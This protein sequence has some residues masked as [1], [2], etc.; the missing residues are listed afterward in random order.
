[1][2]SIHYLIH[3]QPNNDNNNSQTAMELLTNIFMGSK[4]EIEWMNEQRLIRR[5]RVQ[6]WIVIRPKIAQTTN[7]TKKK[8]EQHTPIYT[9]MFL[10]ISCI[11]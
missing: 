8:Q 2:Q 11:A 6:K 4:W 9:V 3:S 7:K 10:L 5:V 1:M